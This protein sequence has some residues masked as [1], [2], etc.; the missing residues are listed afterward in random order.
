MKLSELV[1]YCINTPD[2]DSS[3]CKYYNLCSIITKRVSFTTME[4]I[5]RMGACDIE[6]NEH[7]K[8]HRDVI[9]FSLW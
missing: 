7:A 3:T 6:I 1:E 2:C 4:G 9:D 8:D 5:Y